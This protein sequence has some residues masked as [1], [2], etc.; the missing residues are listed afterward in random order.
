MPQGATISY[1][2]MRMPRPATSWSSPCAVAGWVV[3]IL[4]WLWLGQMGMRLGWSVASGLGAVSLW[5]AVRWAVRD[6]PWVMQWRPEMVL[7]LG[8]ASAGLVGVVAYG[9]SALAAHGVLLILAGIWGLWCA[10]LEAQ[11]SALNL[12]GW[13]GA[14]A[15]AAWHS[16]LA[17]VLVG[18]VWVVPVGAAGPADSVAAA[19][20][21]CGLVLA[22]GLKAEDR[23]TDPVPGQP[24]GAEPLS[25]GLPSIAM[26]LMMG[27][28]WL[29]SEWCANAGLSLGA[30]VALHVALMAVLPAALWTVFA[31]YP[32]WMPNV[33]R[34]RLWVLSLL[35]LSALVILLLPPA[36]GV[37]AMLLLSLAW[38]LDPHRAN[39]PRPVAASQLD[40]H[41]PSVSEDK[42][43]LA[44]RLGLNATVLSA[45]LLGPGML[46]LV[47]LNSAAS[48]PQALRGAL[49]MVGALAALCLVLAVLKPWFS[50]RGVRARLG[51]LVHLQQSTKSNT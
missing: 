38:A 32:G 34:R 41:A 12:K 33:E 5:W 7:G 35:A 15:P 11:L 16:A 9:A 28:L 17:A 2:V 20:L 23:S 30:S 29:G 45:V 10:V 37:W 25:R 40:L 36:H 18:F 6:S 42:R 46:L 47:G 4:G 27:S 49:V 1:M 43:A 44:S 26:G 31:L 21:I 24:L 14:T 50:A 22:V 39:A 51:Q 13:G 8:V 48:G 19:L 3:Q